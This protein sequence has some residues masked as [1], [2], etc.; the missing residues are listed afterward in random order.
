MYENVF[1]ENDIDIHVL[2][3]LRPDEFMSMAKELGVNSWAHRHKIKRALENLSEDKTQHKMIHTDNKEKEL[4]ETEIGTDN[5]YTGDDV[6]ADNTNEDCCLCLN[7]G[8]HTCRLC[9][10]VVCVIR[11]SMPDP[12]SDNESHRIHL[13]GDKRCIQTF[14]CPSCGYIFTTSSELENRVFLIWD[15]YVYISV[16]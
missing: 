9:K 16:G 4:S 6:I 13:D 14:E 12:N 5:Y 10:K 3:D 8:Q 15:L 2:L 7:G 1:I 11:C